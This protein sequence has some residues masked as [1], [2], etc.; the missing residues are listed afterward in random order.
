MR[1]ENKDIVRPYST[2]KEFMSET[3]TN[4]IKNYPNAFQRFPLNKL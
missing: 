4:M 1:K 2:M 3:K